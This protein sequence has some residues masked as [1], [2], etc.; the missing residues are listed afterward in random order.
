MHER[1]WV[2]SSLSKFTD[3]DVKEGIGAIH[4]GGS[5]H[6]NYLYQMEYP[7]EIYCS[8]LGLKHYF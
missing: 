7:T 8:K 3:Y 1:V 6:L 2:F 5:S 4:K